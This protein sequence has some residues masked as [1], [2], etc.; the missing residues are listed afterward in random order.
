VAHSATSAGSSTVTLTK[1]WTANVNDSLPVT[2]SQGAAFQGV[3]RTASRMLTKTALSANAT[4]T[5]SG[6]Q[7]QATETVTIT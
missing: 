4:L 2:A 6:D 1:T 5:T 7:V 3:L